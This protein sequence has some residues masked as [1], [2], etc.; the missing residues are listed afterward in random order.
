MI[1]PDASKHDPR[2]EYL[3]SLIERAGMS[4]RAAA[5][6]IGVSARMMRYYLAAKSDHRARYP[7]QFALEALAR[8]GEKQRAR[9]ALAK[10][11]K[12]QHGSI[13]CGMN[14]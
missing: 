13:V 14:A 5:A 2:P 10:Q 1:K 12:A 6:A 7:E 3:R 8:F 11:G 9:A 4:Q